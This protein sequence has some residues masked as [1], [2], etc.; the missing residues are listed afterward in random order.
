MGPPQGS[1]RLH[2]QDFQRGKA[3]EPSSRAAD[4]IRAGHQSQDRQVA[5]PPNSR[6]AACARRRGD[7]VKRRE[8]ITLLGGA[9]AWP[10]AARAQQQREQ[11]RVGVVIGFTESDPEAGVQIS[12]FRQELRRLGWIE[13]QNIRIDYR[14]PTDQ[15]ERIRAL[16]AE[17]LALSP[18]LIVSMHN[19]VTVLARP[20]G[21]VTGFANFDLSMG[22]KWLEALKEIAP[23]IERIGFILHPETAPHLGYLK[24]AESGT[25]SASSLTLS[26]DAATMP[27]RLSEGFPRSQTAAMA[28]C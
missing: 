2:R 20:S 11:R 16:G 14:Y 19:L 18:D 8:F 27:R 17:L 25:A 15:P 21:N 23:R 10:L 22:G 1:R 9:A 4:Q 5:R 26:T 28:A 6:Q 12:T 3:G 13:E 7:R 24:S